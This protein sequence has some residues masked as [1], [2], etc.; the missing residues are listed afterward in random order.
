MPARVASR[1]R[2]ALGITSVDEVGHRARRLHTGGS[3]ADD[4]EVQ[5]PL[6]DAGG[7]GVGGLEDLD[8]PGA[9]RL[10]VIEGVQRQGV[11]LGPGRVEEVGTRSDREHQ[12]I[13]GEDLTVGGRDGPR[14][15]IDGR[16]GDLLHVDRRLVLE[17][18]AQGTGDVAHGQFPGRDL[19][20][21]RLELVVVV[22][23]E[24]RHRER[25][26]CRAPWRSRHRRSRLPPRRRKAQ[27]RR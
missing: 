11:L 1:S 15:R 27:R 9:Q 19:V 7:V 6:V 23:V 5:R 10:G 17:D 21:E 26:A 20:E 25:R 4:H 16:H 2:N 12:V 3:G 22:L 18:A 8:Q 14:G 13:P 24:Q